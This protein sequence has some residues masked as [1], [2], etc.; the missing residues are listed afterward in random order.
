M[1]R[2]KN[3]SFPIFPRKSH[4]NVKKI[5]IK[6]SSHF[7]DVFNNVKKRNWIILIWLLLF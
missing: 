6:M 3:S 2:D 7:D 5:D 1:Q 4:I